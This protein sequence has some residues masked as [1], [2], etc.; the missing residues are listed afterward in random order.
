MLKALKTYF[1]AHFVGQWTANR[2]EM[3]HDIVRV[4]RY[5]GD[6]ADAGERGLGKTTIAQCVVVMLMLQGHL[7]FP[8][9]IGKNG[10]EARGALE[11]IKDELSGNDLL[12]EDYPEVCAPIRALEGAPQRAAQ[13][14]VDGVRTRIRWKEDHIV[15][16]TVK[17]SKASGAILV[18]RGID[19]SIR[20]MKKRGRRPDFVLVDDPDSEESAESATETAKRIRTIDRAIAGMAGPGKRIARVILCSCI[21][22]RCVAYIFTDPKQKPSWNGKRYKMLVSPPKSEEH[23]ERYILMRQQ[24]QQ[25]GDDLDGRAATEYY[26]K[27]RRVM[28][29]GAKVSDDERFIGEVGA[30]GQPKE[31]SALQHCYNIIADRGMDNFLSECQ[32]DPPEEEMP[33]SSGLSS[34]MV[35]SRLSGTDKG[36]VPDSTVALTAFVDVGR[37]TLHW[38]VVAWKAQAIGVVIDYGVE[39]VHSPA[40]ARDAGRRGGEREQGV[41]HAIMQALRSLRQYWLTDPYCG[42][43]G[44]TTSLMPIGVD[45]GYYSDAVMAFIREVGGDPWRAT[46]GH[47]SAKG[48]QQFRQPRKATAEI[49]KRHIGDNWYA[50]REPQHQVLYHIHS[51]YW[52]RFVHDRLGTACNEPGSMMLYGSDSRVHMSLSKHLTA[53]REETKFITGVG[54]VTKW[55]QYNKNNHWFDAACGCAVL[56]SMVGV[57]LLASGVSKTSPR[58]TGRFTPQERKAISPWSAYRKPRQIIGTGV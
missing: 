40:M 36:I 8:V 53:E 22:R 31:T 10:P 51:D 35:Q 9:F 15:L 56:A 24:G 26:R 11:E 17:G 49:P 52:K 38:M 20:G 13:Q 47:G 5:G 55:V 12:A 19:G 18:A 14:T 1:P 6:Q 58:A 21:N 39:E 2:R 37:Y 45:Y 23:W 32:N 42:L 27:N 34:A 33:E 28:D 4:A 29:Q 46:K 50:T 43:D 41:E 30:D 16:P 25:N 48:M 7:R 57:R 44:A 54:V 3:I